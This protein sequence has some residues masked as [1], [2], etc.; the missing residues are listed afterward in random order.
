[1]IEIWRDV[2]GYES[3]Y[4]VSNLGNVR[5]KGANN[6]LTTRKNNKGYLNVWLCVNA[7]TKAFILHRLVAKAFIDSLCMR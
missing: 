2:V 3:Y 7:K 5:R 4:E 1:M 6:F